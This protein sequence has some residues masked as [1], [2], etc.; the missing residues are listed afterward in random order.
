MKFK[1]FKEWLSKVNETSTTTA[2]VAVFSRPFGG[3]TVEISKKKKKKMD[4]D[5]PRDTGFQY[6]YSALG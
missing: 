1:S 2:D 3:S 6:P 4:I 5:V